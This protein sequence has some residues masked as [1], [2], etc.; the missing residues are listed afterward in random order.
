MVPDLQDMEN[1]IHLNAFLYA[2]ADPVNNVD[3][4]GHDFSLLS[5]MITTGIIGAIG[6]GVAGATYATVYKHADFLSTETLKDTLVGVFAGGAIGAALGAGGWAVGTLGWSGAVDVLASGLRVYAMKMAGTHSTTLG[7]AVIGFLSGLTVGVVY[8]DLEVSIGS[9][10]TTAALYLNQGLVEGIRRNAG[11]I[12]NGTFSED[13]EAISGF[14]ATYGAGTFMQSLAGAGFITLAFAGGFTLGY[15]SGAG[16]RLLI[17]K[18][19]S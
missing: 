10:V 15:E 19:D 4:S 7:A 18:L 12:D 9:A 8:P 16:L 6:G 5:V 13:L 1:P 3:P 14:A 2:G 11:K 17:H